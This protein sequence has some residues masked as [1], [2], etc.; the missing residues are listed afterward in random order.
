M[1][2]TSALKNPQH[3]VSQFFASE[4][5]GLAAVVQT[6]KRAMRPWQLTVPPPRELSPALAA[7]VGTALDYGIRMITWPAQFMETLDHTAAAMGLNLALTPDHFEVWLSWEEFTQ[8]LRNRLACGAT[9]EDIVRWTYLLAELEERY[10]SGARAQLS[11]SVQAVIQG[12]TN[13]ETAAEAIP[14][15]MEVDLMQLLTAY[16]EGWLSRWRDLPVFLNPTFDGSRDVGGA[17]ADWIVDTVLWDL[18]TTKNPERNLDRDIRQLLGYVF[19]DYS[20][21]YHLSHVAIYYPRFQQMLQWPVN[22]L[23]ETALGKSRDL[24]KWRA[25]WQNSLREQNAR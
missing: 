2:L 5:P 17:D 11:E 23:L 14:Q 15:A 1:S 7:R 25:R 18:K 13:W 3:P 9:L 8:S 10:R 4:C 24:T 12:R 21:R 19:L 16:Q 22:D 20:D 6:A